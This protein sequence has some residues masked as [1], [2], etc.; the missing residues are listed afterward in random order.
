MVQ[1]QHANSR[2]TWETISLLGMLG[3]S[4]RVRWM[5]QQSFGESER[6]ARKVRA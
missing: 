4:P 2:R 1:Q 5:S 3:T 6:G